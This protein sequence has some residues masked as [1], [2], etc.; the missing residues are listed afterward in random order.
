MDFDTELDSEMS[1]CQYVFPESRK[2]KQFRHPIGAH[3]IRF[4]TLAKIE[5]WVSLDRFPNWLDK[6][7]QLQSRD[8]YEVTT[9]PTKCYWLAYRGEY[10]QAMPL[11][12]CS[13]T[14]KQ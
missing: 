8:S 12:V 2:W 7:V 3:R 5:V 11:C 1:V 9:D 13:Y 10:N 14:R 6:G 4:S